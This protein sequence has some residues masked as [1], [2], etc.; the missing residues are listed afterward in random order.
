MST[1][2]N[3][4]KF[5]YLWFYLQILEKL[6]INDK[7]GKAGLLSMAMDNRE[8]DNNGQNDDDKKKG[9]VKT[10]VIVCMILVLYISTLFNLPLSILS[11][12]SS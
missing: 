12:N 10:S 2:I 3:D 9:E 11:I 1:Y 7:T 5:P 8:N 6:L 4:K